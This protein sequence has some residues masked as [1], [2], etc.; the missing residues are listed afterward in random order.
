M[1]LPL[2]YEPDI[3]DGNNH[4]KLSE[5]TARHCLQVLRMKKGDAMQLTDGK[6]NLFT[7]TIADDNKKH[8]IVNIKNK[9][10]YN[11]ATPF[12]CI[13]IAPVKNTSRLE[14]FIEKSTEIGINQIV[15]LQTKRTEKYHYKQERLQSIEVSAMLQSRQ[16]W[17]PCIKSSKDL[18]EFITDYKTERSFIAHCADDD[19]KVHLSSIKNLHQQQS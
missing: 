6:G 18:K 13:A 17:L 16:T 2:F 7:V 5:A 19:N 10:F 11:A 15:L 1:Q 9:E 3:Q 8:C 12:I 14:W 4:F